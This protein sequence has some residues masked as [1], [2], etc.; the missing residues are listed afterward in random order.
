ML[1][2]VLRSYVADCRDYCAGINSHRAFI[3]NLVAVVLL[4]VSGWY[5]GELIYRYG[6]AVPD[7]TCE[8]ASSPRLN[9]LPENQVLQVTG[10]ARHFHMKRNSNK[11]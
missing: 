5:G 3:L 2:S 7:E 11:R 1:S 8:R 4:L 6:V 10:A 9:P